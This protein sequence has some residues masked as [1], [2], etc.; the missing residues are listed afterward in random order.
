VEINLD[1]LFQAKGIFTIVALAMILYFLASLSGHPDIGNSLLNIAYIIVIP[2]V[3][4]YI[5]KSI[6]EILR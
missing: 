5:L 3:F 2:F 4:I 6:I 1:F